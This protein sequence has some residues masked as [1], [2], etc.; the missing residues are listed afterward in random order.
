MA[1]KENEDIVISN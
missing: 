1:T